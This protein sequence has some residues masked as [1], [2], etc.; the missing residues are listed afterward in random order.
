[1]KKSAIFLC[2][3]CLAAIAHEPGTEVSD[4]TRT[5][6]FEY[7]NA[8]NRTTRKTEEPGQEADAGRSTEQSAASSG[9]GQ[10]SQ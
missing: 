5:V 9:N 7:D 10:E 8:G 3:A 6:V 2:A 4:S 1:M